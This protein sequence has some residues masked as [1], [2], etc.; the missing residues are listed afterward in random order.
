MRCETLRMAPATGDCKP[1]RGG[2]FTSR[3]AKAFCYQMFP[4]PGVYWA[5]IMM[6][7][8]IVSA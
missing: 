4:A 8:C 2:R 3:F 5:A 6:L 1:R 7:A